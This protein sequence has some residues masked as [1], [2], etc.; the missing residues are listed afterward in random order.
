MPLNRVIPDFIEGWMEY[1]KISEAPNLY[2]EWTAVSLIAT[3]LSR[4][5]FHVWEKNIYP[6]FFILLVGPAGGRK[7]TAMGP[8]VKLL[9]ACDV[10]I[11]ADSITNEALIKDFEQAETS[12]T[13]KNGA[14]ETYCPVTVHAEEFTVLLARDDGKM[15]A[16]LTDWFDCKDLWSYKTKHH[17]EFFLSN[18]F[19]NMLGATTP[20][21]FSELLPSTAVGGGLLSRI[22]IV[23]ANKKSALIPFPQRGEDFT[24]LFEYLK[25][26]FQI[27]QSYQG[28]FYFD[29]E[30]NQA[31]ERFY[32]ENETQPPFEGV[33]H[34]ERY[35]TR[36]PTHF[37]KLSMIMAAS[38]CDCNGIITKADFDRAM[39]LLLRTEKEMPKAFDDMGE[40]DHVS[41]IRKVLTFLARKKQA[42]VADILQ[43]YYKDIDHATLTL[44]LE[45]LVKAKKITRELDNNTGFYTYFWPKEGEV[46]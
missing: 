12:Y 19:F 37:R 36:R 9:R 46:E 44:V 27:L 34:L 4:K 1:N 18:L 21:V 11:T 22:I 6:N 29:E 45:S 39:D 17:G 40:S 20:S 2:K 23:H 33:E 5:C 41:S 32:I 25:A 35:V 43:V 7:G 3:A 14:V 42:T 15:I 28:E 38:R 16:N 30:F 10:P 24:Q 8:A 26:D 31:Y 13:R